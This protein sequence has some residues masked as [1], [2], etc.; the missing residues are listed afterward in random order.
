MLLNF[1]KPPTTETQPVPVVSSPLVSSPTPNPTRIATDTSTPSG[2]VIAGKPKLFKIGTV[3]LIPDG[4][5]FVSRLKDGNYLAISERCTHQGCA[6]H[7]VADQTQFQC[8]CHGSLFD[9][10]GGVIRDP[11][12]RPLDLFPITVVNGDLVVDTSSPLQ[13]DKFE[14]S[15]EK[16]I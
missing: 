1:L 6:V 3:T 14:K 12:P 4:H 13:R 9:N 5:F 8:P 15:Q 7:W 10:T 16:K 2:P 11:A